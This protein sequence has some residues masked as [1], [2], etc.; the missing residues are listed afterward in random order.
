MSNWLET[1]CINWNL[2]EIDIFIHPESAMETCHYS[3]YVIRLQKNKERLQA[4]SKK[5]CT[6]KRAQKK[7]ARK[8]CP[9]QL[10]NKLFAKKYRKIRVAFFQI[11]RGPPVVVILSKENQNR[12]KWALCKNH[13]HFIKTG[14]YQDQRA[15][16]D[17][18]TVIKSIFLF[19]R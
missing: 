10:N 15:V 2:W 18:K 19:D 16:E 5:N 6:K 11:T 1:L 4:K 13:E 7:L 8:R 3:G 9:S 17:N 14:F 12:Q